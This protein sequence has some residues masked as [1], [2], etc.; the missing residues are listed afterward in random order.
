M[1]TSFSPGAID[2]EVG[3]AMF[4]GQ[5]DVHVLASMSA[6]YVIHSLVALD[7]GLDHGTIC[8]LLEVYPLGANVIGGKAHGGG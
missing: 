2:I 4:R 6:Q 8:T 5:A 3:G 1:A 7:A